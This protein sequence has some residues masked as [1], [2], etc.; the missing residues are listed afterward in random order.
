MKLQAVIKVAYAATNMIFCHQGFR[1]RGLKLMKIFTWVS[2]EV[3]WKRGKSGTRKNS[4]P[5]ILKMPFI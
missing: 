2:S 4:I 3:R 1:K 5:G